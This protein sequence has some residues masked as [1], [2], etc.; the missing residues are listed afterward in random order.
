[1]RYRKLA[2][3]VMLVSLPVIMFEGLFPL[4]TKQLGYSTFQMTIFYSAFALA[5]LVM[6]FFMGK[7]SDKYTRRRVFL[8]AVLLYAAAYISLSGAVSMPHIMAARFIQGAAG[9]LLTLS[10]VGVITDEN[11]KFAQTMG[12]F[13][14]NRNLG[15]M[16]GVGLCFLIFTNY[17]LLSG[18]NIF[19]LCCFG[20][21]LSA[22]LYSLVKVR[23]QEKANVPRK[24]KVVFSVEKKKLWIFN[25]FFCLFASMTGVLLIPYVTAAFDLGMESLISVFFFPMVVSSFAGPHL[26]RLGDTFGYRRVMILSAFL[27]SLIAILVPMIHTPDSFTIIWTLYVLSISALDYSMDALFV[28]GIEEHVIGDYYGKYAFGS[29]IGHILGPLAGGYLFD[30]LGISTPYIIFAV[31]MLFFAAACIR[32]MPKGNRT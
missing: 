18:W 21:S 16:I 12:R 13:D 8:F 19:F 22:Y 15:G 10:V 23:K 26:G 6:R 2:V 7:L 1:M 28:Q 11:D 31:C 25:L 17:D 20:A 29:N 32:Y 27:L 14:S 24:A 3:P 5:G 9:I 30:H 4:Y